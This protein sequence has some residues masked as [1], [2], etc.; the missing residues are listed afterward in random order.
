MET[1]VSLDLLESLI[2]CDKD[3]SRHVAESWMDILEDQ[4][5]KYSLAKHEDDED[6][7]AVEDTNIP[8]KNFTGLGHLLWWTLSSVKK[9]N[10]DDP[11][12]LASNVFVPWHSAIDDFLC[13]VDERRSHEDLAVLLRIIEGEF[14]NYGE[15]QDEDNVH[16]REEVVDF[17]ESEGAG[18]DAKQLEKGCY[19]YA[20][21][22]ALVNYPTIEEATSKW[23]EVY[24]LKVL[25]VTEVL[26][27]SIKYQQPVLLP[28]TS[29]QVLF[30]ETRN[31]WD[32][33]V[34]QRMVDDKKTYDIENDRSNTESDFQ[35]PKCSSFKTVYYPLQMRSADEP[36]AVLWEC[37]ECNK[38]GVQK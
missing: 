22:I 12:Y 10:D 36:M 24:Y 25:E 34:E 7:D 3:N 33:A 8:F 2:D 13:L 23:K 16:L 4:L 17:L 31:D 9:F 19:L 1:E 6:D 29:R 15:F 32:Q 5:A 27:R 20:S 38:S 35:C 18:D 21:I 26:N 30:A 37:H 11:E 28:F 14:N